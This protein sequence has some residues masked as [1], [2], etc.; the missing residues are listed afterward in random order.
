MAETNITLVKLLVNIKI[1]KGTIVLSH[2]IC[3]TLLWQ[4]QETNAHLLMKRSQT[5]KE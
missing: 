3:G 5:K 2:L 4:P 1:L